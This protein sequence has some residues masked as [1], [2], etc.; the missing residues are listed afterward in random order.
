ML[1]RII[2]CV[3]LLIIAHTLVVAQ[4]RPTEEIQENA[5]ARKSSHYI[6]I[7]AN[8][9]LRQLISFGGNSSPVSN[10]YSLVYSVN[11]NVNGFG[12]T[13]GLGYSAQDSKTTDQ[14][15]SIT[16][17]TSEFAWRIGLEKRTYLSRHWLIGLGGDILVESAKTETSNKGNGVTTSITTDS[18]RSGFGPRVSLNFQFHRRL[19]VGTEAAYYFRWIKQKQTSIGTGQ[20]NDPATSLRSFAFTLPAV[21]FLTF[22][23]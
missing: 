17:K 18:K 1:I 13:T 16:T 15:S 6:G 10:P 22:K 8:Q 5:P 21:I 12:L 19:M 3:I 20:A 11:S 23:V 9:L 14:F 2:I 4:T 7:Q